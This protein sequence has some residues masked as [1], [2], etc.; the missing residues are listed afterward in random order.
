MSITWEKLQSNKQEIPS[1]RNSGHM[2]QCI[3][4]VKRKYPDAAIAEIEPRKLWGLASGDV[5]LSSP[6][7]SH[8]E[9]WAEARAAIEAA[10]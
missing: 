4:I 6:H 8:Y 2:L 10:Q 5:H 1:L 9:C 3:E 7:K